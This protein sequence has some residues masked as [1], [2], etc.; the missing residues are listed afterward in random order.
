MCQ[1]KD[2]ARKAGFVVAPSDRFLENVLQVFRTDVWGHAGMVMQQDWGYAFACEVFFY[3]LSA[4]TKDAFLDC[5]V[6]AVESFHYSEKR[7]AT[8]GGKVSLSA[9]QI[10]RQM[11]FSNTFA[12]VR[13]NHFAWILDVSHARVEIKD[14]RLRINPSGENEMFVSILVDR[15]RGRIP[16]L[17]KMDAFEL[18]SCIVGG[19]PTCRLG[20]G[21]LDAG[22]ASTGGTSIPRAQ[23]WGGQGC[24][25]N[26]DRLIELR[27]DQISTDRV[28]FAIN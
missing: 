2:V 3:C 8:F 22:S 10:D 19:F 28:H 21:R 13:P 23:G 24:M 4:L 12:T 1:V 25:S 11:R 26:Q 16:N 5:G 15:L 9:T 20:S 17:C 27:I 14:S 7:L 6:A 18:R